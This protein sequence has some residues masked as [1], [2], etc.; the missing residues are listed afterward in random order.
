MSERSERV[1][2]SLD[3]CLLELSND[4]LELIDDRLE[5]FDIS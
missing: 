5:A 1:V 4:R 3:S 2:S